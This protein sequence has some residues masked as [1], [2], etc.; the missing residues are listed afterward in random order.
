MKKI[1]AFVMAVVLVLSLFTLAGCKKEKNLYKDLEGF[2]SYVSED[3]DI[4]GVWKETS[5]T[6]EVEWTFYD[7]TTL[8]MT[9]SANSS[10][11]TVCTYNYDEQAN[12][13]SIYVFSNKTIYDYTVDI[14]GVELTLTSKSDGAERIFKKIG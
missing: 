9:R 11:T 7:T 2:D 3:A 6:D 10:V 14:S 13:L 1:L 4:L 12:T 5:T 8:H